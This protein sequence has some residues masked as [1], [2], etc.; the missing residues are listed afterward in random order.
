M[1]A[2][3]PI[4]LALVLNGIFLAALGRNP[5]TF[6]A[7][8]FESGVFEWQGLQNGIIRS[9]PLLLIAAGLVV[10]FQ[11]HLWNLGANGQFLLG[12]AF[13]AGFAPSLLESTG[14]APMLVLTLLVA[15]LA[16]AIWTLVPSWLRGKYGVNEIVTS[17]MM[18]FIG[19]G[20]AQLLVKGPFKTKLPGAGAR[21]EVVPYTQRLPEIFGTRIHLGFV[22]AVV[23]MLAVHVLMTRTSLGLKFRVLG[24]NPRA[25]LHSGLNPL[26]LTIVAFAISGALVGASG[27]VDIL[28]YQG[29]FRSEYDPAYG[30]LV[31]PLVFL[32]RLNAIG[33]LFLV[34]GFAVIQV[35]GE[36]AARKAGLTPDVMLVLV[37]LVLLMM[38]MMEY[39]RARRGL[40]TQVLPEDIAKRLRADPPRDGG[41]ASE[42]HPEIGASG[43]GS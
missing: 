4:V 13:T 14:V 40:S 29:S 41:T 6:Y 27:W 18:S 15:A 10:A 42:M 21:T 25:A 16:G 38:G 17:L 7:N 22:I 8:T 35:G 12:A 2:M 30:L 9:A 43:A 1:V 20:V 39:L 34:L 19:I 33:S 3:V 37:G 5:F 24:A 11:S 32:A 26:R 36:A 23:A 28:G 31:V